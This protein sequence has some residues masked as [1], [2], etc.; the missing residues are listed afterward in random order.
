MITYGTF[1]PSGCVTVV[2]KRLAVGR[3]ALSEQKI[4][5]HPV[6]DGNVMNS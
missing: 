4:S 1:L 5:V 6:L 3:C 2:Y